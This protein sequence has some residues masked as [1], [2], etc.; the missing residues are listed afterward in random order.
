ME[1]SKKWLKLLAWAGIQYLNY[2]KG[3][4]WG[5]CVEA[6][7]WV[8]VVKLLPTIQ[9]TCLMPN[10][11]KPEFYLS[12]N[13]QLFRK[14]YTSGRL[15]RPLARLQIQVGNTV[16]NTSNSLPVAIEFDNSKHQVSPCDIQTCFSQKPFILGN[17]LE[18]ATAHNFLWYKRMLCV[19]GKR[20]FAG[21]VARLTCVSSNNKGVKLCLQPVD[22]ETVCK[23]HMCLDAPTN[24]KGDTIRRLVHGEDGLEELKNSRLPNSLGVNTLLFTADSK[25][26]IQRRSRKVVAFG[27]LLG[28]PSSGAFDAIDFRY[29]GKGA[30]FPFLRETQE[31]LQI[32]YKDICPGSEKFLGI[33]RELLRGGKP[34]MFFLART[35]LSEDQVRKRRKNARD[36]WESSDLK[37]WPFHQS[38]FNTSLSGAQEDRFRTD[39]KE[40]FDKYPICLMSCPLLSALALW[41]NDVLSRKARLPGR[42]TANP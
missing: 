23:T 22:Y 21:E 6:L 40:L 38:V 15:A 39:M 42:P 12:P 10:R 9:N 27:S 3:G 17:D 11:L 14:L 16:G 5:S 33:T 37:F 34:E 20:Y 30:P 41:Q 31:E 29:R 24:K 7:I 8:W 28:P 13:E 18:A 4:V 1:N 19:Y 32:G 36:K 2:C 25:L 26:I 35:Q